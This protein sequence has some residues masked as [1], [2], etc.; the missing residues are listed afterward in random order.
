MGNP[1]GVKRNFETLE[2]RRMEG[3][4]LLR[5]GIK[6]AEVARRGGAHR[7]SVNR[8]ASELAANWQRIFVWRS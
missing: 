2:R 3:A 8:W 1:A 4:R 7:H 6:E 5:P